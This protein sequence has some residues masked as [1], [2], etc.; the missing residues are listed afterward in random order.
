M[1]KSLKDLLFISLI[2]LGGCSVTIYSDELEQANNLCTNN[3]GL[4]WF[5]VQATAPNI[6]AHCSDGS[7]R[8]LWRKPK[9]H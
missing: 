7:T 1:A 3:G 6:L 4:R 2:F 9:T 5:K 8:S